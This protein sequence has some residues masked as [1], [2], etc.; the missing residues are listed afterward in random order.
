MSDENGGNPRA[1]PQRRYFF[2]VV[3]VGVMVAAAYSAVLVGVEI[4]GIQ[5][6]LEASLGTIALVVSTMFSVVGAFSTILAN[7]L[8]RD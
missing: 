8:R 2:A 7:L 5:E 1:V 3:V 4:L 6:S